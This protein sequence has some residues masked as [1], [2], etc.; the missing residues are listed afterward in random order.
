MKFI[1]DENMPPSLVSKLK[2]LGY[3]TYHVNEIGFSN[4]ADSKITELAKRENSII[5]TH[6]TD[7]GTIMALNGDN[8]PSI[9]LFRW[10][11][12]SVNSL[13]L[14]L[15]EYLPQLELDLEKG[16]FIVVD[17][18]KIRVRTLPLVK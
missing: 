4:T 10:Q 14:F 1:L 9:I 16:S 2:S 13:F 12:I 7:F 8:K 15:E 6:D 11:I 17:D 18:N 3:E 5:I